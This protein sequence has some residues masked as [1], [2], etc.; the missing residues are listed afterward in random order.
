[1]KTQLTSGISSPQYPSKVGQK[2][3]ILTHLRIS[4]L[5]TAGIV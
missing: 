1:M 2:E 3:T 5:N 4:I